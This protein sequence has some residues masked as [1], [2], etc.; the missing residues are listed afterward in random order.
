MCNCKITSIFTFH[1]FI[2]QTSSVIMN[3]LSS[4]NH[5]SL[6]IFCTTEQA[7]APMSFFEAKKNKG[8][9]RLMQTFKYDRKKRLSLS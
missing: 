1:C 7:V 5:I 4:I 2:N 9:E 6:Q 3:V 8:R